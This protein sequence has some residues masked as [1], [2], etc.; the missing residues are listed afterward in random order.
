MIATDET[1]YLLYPERYSMH[2]G[3]EKDC[4]E[5]PKDI[6]SKA[7]MLENT[8]CSRYTYEED[9]LKKICSNIFLQYTKYS[10]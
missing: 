7:N 8:V 3:I 10:A 4:R 9:P 1:L 6:F 2:E 5:P